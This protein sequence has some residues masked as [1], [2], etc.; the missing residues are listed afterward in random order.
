MAT[1]DAINVHLMDGHSFSNDEAHQLQPSTPSNAAV[2]TAATTT[3]NAITVQQSP[4]VKSSDNM[5]IKRKV[6]VTATKPLPTSVVGVALKKE[7]EKVDHGN[8]SDVIISQINKDSLFVNT[9]LQVGMKI[10]SING[11]NCSNYSTAQAVALLKN[12]IGTI[13][14]VAI[15]LEATIANDSVPPSATSGVA[16]TTTITPMIITV[17]AIKP[18]PDAIV[19]I[20]LQKSPDKNGIFISQINH[21]SIFC[22]TDL[23]VGLKV[24][25]INSLKIE[26]T[27]SLQDVISILRNAPQ[28]PLT[29]IALQQDMTTTTVAPTTDTMNRNNNDPTMTQHNKNNEKEKENFCSFCFVCCECLGECCELFTT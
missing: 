19:G 5:T 12:A 20:S 15:D 11:I 6:T 7:K 9:E 18:S 24:L 29:I 4:S 1:A 14:I 2:A 8:E 17:T 21:D 13:T 28:G 23:K 25:S 27:I 16:T 10:E 3:T 22:N 26:D